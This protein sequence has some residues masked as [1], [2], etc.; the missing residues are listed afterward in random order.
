M[1]LLSKSIDEMLELMANAYDALIAPKRIYRNDKNK[2][3]LMF[4]GNAAG[5]SVI[6]D[7]ALALHDRFDPEK[8][9]DED[10]YSTAKMVGTEFKE[11][12]GSL[13]QIIAT[14]NDSV[15][16]KI[17]TVGVYNYLST[18]GDIFSFTVSVEISIP[19]SGTKQISAMSV[20]KGSFLVS[21]NSNISV[22]RQDGIAIDGSIGFSCLDNAGSLG[23]PDE[24]PWDFRVR[25]L[26]DTDRQDAI[27]E[28]ELKIRNLPN[29]LECNLVFNQY[30]ENIVYDG[31]T[32][33]PYHLLIVVTGAPD[34]SLAKAVVSSTIHHTKMVDPLKVVHFYDS[35]YIDG[36]CPVYYTNHLSADFA[37]EITYRYDGTK[38][39]E[40]SVEL[41][42]NTALNVYRNSTQHVD[43]LVESDVYNL[44]NALGMPS[45]KVLNIDILVSGVPVSY[46]NINK[47]RALNLTGVTLF[48]T[49]VS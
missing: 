43:T 33:L 40:G 12:S 17:L 15:L 39:R 45:V 2:I 31:I 25:I 44:I 28:L 38:I 22:S 30:A 9:A 1:G 34:D 49:D 42:V 20:E 3:W 19:A 7:S 47:T 23:Y 18:N 26:E 10:L 27:N 21:A 6:Q 29:I 16:A 35:H 41:Q 11:G 32:L 36:A 8:S 5:Y 14:N 46:F 37:L 4:R 48:G 13:L 24:T